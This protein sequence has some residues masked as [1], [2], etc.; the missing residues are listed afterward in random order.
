M[1]LKE[2][3]QFKDPDLDQSKRK[4]LIDFTIKLP[5]RFKRI[6]DFQRPQGLVKSLQNKCNHLLKETNNLKNKETRK[7]LNSKKF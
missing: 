4:Q 3:S 5:R 1:K 6:F 2:K 7:F